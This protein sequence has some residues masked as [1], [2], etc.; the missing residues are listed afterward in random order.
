MITYIKSIWKWLKIVI[1]VALLAVLG[2]MIWKYSSYKEKY[3]IAK[4][5][6]TAFIAQ[7]NGAKEEVNMFKFSLDQMR[8]IQDSSIQRM[9]HVI[10]SLK[11]KDKNINQIQ[12]LSTT[13]VKQDT[14]MVDDTIF[15]EPEF[16][17]DTLVGDK[18]VQT[19]LHLEYPGTIALQPSVKSEKVCIVNLKK[20]P[21]KPPKKTWI[22]RLF[23]KKHKVVKVNIIESNPYVTDQEN[24]FIEVVK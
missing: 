15:L 9:V 7:L 11:L 21:I 5:N 1:V 24:T 13:I 4:N 14:I 8:Y 19:K 16:C 18:W 22:G 6:E 17:M 3:E 20:E 10:D 12:Y 2:I 23:Q